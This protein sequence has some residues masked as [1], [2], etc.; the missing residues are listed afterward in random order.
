VC[1]LV[2][3]VQLVVLFVGVQ[4]CVIESMLCVSF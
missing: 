1:P 3:N 4:M 2:Q